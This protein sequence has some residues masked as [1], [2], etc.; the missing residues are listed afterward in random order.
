MRAAFRLCDCQGEP[1]G[2]IGV[3]E[4]RYCSDPP[5]APASIEVGIKR[6]AEFVTSNGKWS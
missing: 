2:D 4:P 3:R 1:P 6:T 5:I